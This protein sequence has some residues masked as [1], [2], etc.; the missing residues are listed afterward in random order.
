MALI[1]KSAEA[2]FFLDNQEINAPA[3]AFD[4]SFDI[5][6]GDEIAQGA[7]INVNELV[8]YGQTRKYLLDKIQEGLTGGVG[9]FEGLSFRIQLSNIDI[10][11]IAYDGFI[12]LSDISD[13]PANNR[14]TVTLKK[15]DGA[16]TLQDRID[17]LTFGN[18]VDEGIITPSDYTTFG[19]V[20]KKK[21]NLLEQ[22]TNSIVLY[23]LFKELAELIQ[24]QGDTTA[25][26][27][28]IQAGGGLTGSLGA[29]IYSVIKTAIDIAY[30]L[31]MVALL[32]RLSRQLINSFLPPKREHKLLNMKVG[33]EKIA[34]KL[35]YDL[36][37]GEDVQEINNHY[38]LP[39]NQ[40]FDEST[41][42]GLIGIARGTSQGIP[43]ASDYGYS[44]A[45]FVQYL[46]NYFYASLSVEDGSL[47]FDWKGSDYYEKQASVELFDSL[48]KTFSYNTEDAVR[49]RLIQF[50]TD[51]TDDYTIDNFRGTNYEVLTKPKTVVNEK[52]VTLYGA[53]NIDLPL[54][55][56]NRNNK[57][58]ALEEGVKGLLNVFDTI[59]NALGGAFGVNVNFSSVVTSKIGLLNVSENNHS[60]PK[61]IYLENGRLPSNHR[62]KFSAKDSYRYHS[63]KSFVTNGDEAQ[64]KK[65]TNVE[66]PFGL[67]SFA[68]LI[69]NSYLY[70]SDGK[71]SKATRLT[72]EFLKDR[73][74]V[75]YYERERYTNNLEE[76]F[77]EIG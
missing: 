63:Y 36:V 48:N 19:Y 5:E 55:L 74:E 70:N 67:E 17:A 20:V 18:L 76:T 10:G 72:W 1:G 37:I 29:G 4:L 30:A 59:V 32:I 57:L 33:L 39:S 38:Y 15:T 23:L 41:I 28:G 25:T 7:Q 3:G 47:R 14:C 52:Y 31:A 49:S 66:I 51:I 54:S 34:E 43:N 46:L 6:F 24:R 75:D 61:V 65:F 50:Q 56:G 60:I 12:A 68:K 11:L 69:N 62:E 8:F 42:D 9:I 44:C 21:F 27:V 77:I 58:N 13:D 2:S 53:E 26:A 73:A 71:R 22:L 35:G 45:E 16:S 64:K 40:N